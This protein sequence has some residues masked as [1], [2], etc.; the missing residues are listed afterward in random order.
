MLYL[1][2]NLN[3]YIL[4]RYYIYG[5]CRLR[6]MNLPTGTTTSIVTIQLQI[7]VKYNTCLTYTLLV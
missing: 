7:D 5:G 1:F 6:L 3:C 4:L 2:L